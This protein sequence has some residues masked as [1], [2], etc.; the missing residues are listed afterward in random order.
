MRMRLLAV[1]ALSSGSAS[2]AG[3]QS[4][5][6]AAFI[7]RLG[8]DTTAIERY[9]RTPQ[10]LIAEAVQR[11]PTTMLHRL[12][13]RFGARGAITS[14]EWTVLRPGDT[15]PVSR[16]LIRFQGDTAL[17]ENTQGGTTRTQNVQA[18]D[19]IPIAGPFY[20]P[21]ELAMMRAM[22]SGANRDTVLL[23]PGAATA[24]IRLERVG[25]D[26]MA[27][28]NQFDEPLRAHVDARG[29]LLHL[30][31]RAY[32]SVERIRW[33]D[34]NHWA[35]EFATRDAAGRA[36]GPLSP[37]VTT[38]QRFGAANVWL[39][40]S[41]PAKRGRPVWG[42]LV[43][44]DQ[45]WRM[46]A[47]DAAHLATDRPLEIGHVTLSPGTYTLFLLPAQSGWQLII[48][49][50]TG[51]SGLEYDAALDVER[52][53]LRV[54]N[55]ERP[56]ESFTIDLRPAANGGTIAIAWDNRSASVPFRVQ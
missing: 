14:G 15:Q 34:L 10:Q 30:H 46:G 36:L 31:T 28:N 42:A 24:A 45:V 38:R 23:L 54:E 17:I 12:T 41:R 53:P 16:R 1:L 8:V 48:N 33:I 20:T 7:I 25:R 43:P 47:N 21:Y 2:M 18:P 22:A 37:R 11:S 29:R 40:Y 51:M 19:A 5:D 44:W 6:S 35:R 27:L 4:T 26:S 39:D 56:V 32:A 9:V 3:A 49:R 13:L 52:I 50:S 55:L